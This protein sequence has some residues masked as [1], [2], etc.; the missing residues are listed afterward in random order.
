[1]PASR[2]ISACHAAGS[3]RM[4]RLVWRNS[5]EAPPS[6][7]YEASVKGAPAKPTSGTR[8]ASALRDEPYRLEDEAHR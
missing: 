5:R 7:R 1:M 8:S 2:A 6:M 4:K 3:A